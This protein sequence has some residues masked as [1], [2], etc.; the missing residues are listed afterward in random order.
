MRI[1]AVWVAAAAL[2]CSPSGAT[3]MSHERVAGDVEVRPTPAANHAEEGEQAAAPLLVPGDPDVSRLL[4]DVVADGVPLGEIMI[5]HDTDELLA[6][7]APGRTL[8]L[9]GSEYRVPTGG[10]GALGKTSQLTLVGDTQGSTRIVQTKLSDWVLTLDSVSDVA[11][12]NLEL[13]FTNEDGEFWADEKGVD[14]V[15][16]RSCCGTLLVRS[17]RNVRLRNVALNT[18]GRSTLDVHD[19]DGLSVKNSVISARAHLA[20]MAASRN[21]E[22]VDTLFSGAEPKSRGFALESTQLDIAQSWIGGEGRVLFT[23]DPPAKVAPALRKRTKRSRSVAHAGA[24]TVRLRDSVVSRHGK[25]ASRPDQVRLSSTSIKNGPFTS[26]TGFENGRACNCQRRHGPDG[27]T[28]ATS[29]WSTLDA[30]NREAQAILRGKEGVLPAS[31]L[32]SCTMVYGND[33]VE[34]GWSSFFEQGH[35]Q[36]VRLGTCSTSGPMVRPPMTIPSRAT[37]DAWHDLG[38]WDAR[39]QESWWTDRAPSAVAVRV[40]VESKLDTRRNVV[41]GSELTVR[42]GEDRVPPELA[43]HR[44][45]V[46]TKRGVITLD[47]WS[48][49][50]Y[51]PRHRDW[52]VSHEIPEG[53]STPLIALSK[54]PLHDPRPRLASP[55]VT[56]GPDS[57]LVLE[58]RRML[59]IVRQPPDRVF[60]REIQ[61]LEGRFPGGAT[62]VVTVHWTAFGDGLF[63]S[64]HHVSSVFTADAD[65]RPVQW[66][67]TQC[68]SAWLDFVA[69]LD[70]DGFDE[71]AWTDVFSWER[72]THYV[73]HLSET[74]ADTRMLASI[75]R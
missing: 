22:I 23:L 65:D 63:T 51:D 40:P 4:E 43:R 29:C 3:P 34:Q 50:K 44:A 35:E 36:S 47:A 20:R 5:V 2:G 61:V 11:L 24:S 48:V 73:T 16:E 18:G 6:A 17:S 52:V 67:C 54:T 62:R 60:E 15:G 21:V 10:F 75:A 59:G 57:P 25:L 39:V 56:A 69:D 12:Y 7:V 70:G 26:M 41:D 42:P 64:T 58:A 13:E 49:A 19:V 33:E 66:L 72:R 46:L 31:S 1:M 28:L 45:H 68:H 8:V 37:D 9:Y 27:W 74:L 38:T 14:F 30:C 53:F 71:V 32:D 55:G